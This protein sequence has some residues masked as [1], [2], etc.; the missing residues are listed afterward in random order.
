ML[1]WEAQKELKCDHSDKVY[2]CHVAGSLGLLNEWQTPKQTSRL[3]ARVPSFFQWLIQARLHY[4]FLSR[5]IRYSSYTSKSV[6]PSQHVYMLVHISFLTWIGRNKVRA[7]SFKFNSYAVF[8]SIPIQIHQSQKATTKHIT[9]KTAW[10]YMEEKAG[11]LLKIRGLGCLTVHMINHL[12]KYIRGSSLMQP[13]MANL[14]SPSSR[15]VKDSTP[16]RR[17][18]LRCKNFGKGESWPSF[19][20]DEVNLYLMK[21]R[22]RWILNERTF[23]SF[24]ILFIWK[25]ILT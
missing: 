10:F 18:I 25:W 16:F 24:I 9:A 3:T 12:F 20:L 14:N 23:Y 5:V 17:R 6:L 22:H 2:L 1:I 4:V 13:S 21:F 15:V 7:Y 11:R 19:F 8:I